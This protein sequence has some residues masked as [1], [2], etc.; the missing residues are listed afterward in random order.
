M[1]KID[2]RFLPQLKRDLATGATPADTIDPSLV[3]I[4]EGATLPSL[5]CG[6]RCSEL[7]EWLRGTGS[8]AASELP[9]GCLAG[10][11]LLAGDLDA[12]HQISQSD[13]T[14]EGSFWHGIMHRREG[15]FDNA[16][17]WFRR[18]GNHR[19]LG[20][21]AGTDY[22]DPDQFVDRCKD[23]TAASTEVL[24]A[25][26]WNEWQHLFFHCLNNRVHGG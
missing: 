25:L 16:K 23:A 9:S 20:Q 21:L 14:P 5:R 24:V 18:V 6:P 17:Y 4:I 15:D 19:V 8:A 12:S 1:P 7:L 22:G 11:W 10:L 13:P 3:K 2:P 26:Q